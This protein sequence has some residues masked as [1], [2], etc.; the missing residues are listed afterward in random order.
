MSQPLTKE[1]IEAMSREI[2]AFILGCIF[3]LCVT[4]IV[5]VVLVIAVVK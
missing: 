3:T 2:K 4:G 1:D 5:S